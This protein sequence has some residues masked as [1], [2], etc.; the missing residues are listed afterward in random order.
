[1]TCSLK[2]SIFLIRSTFLRQ[3]TWRVGYDIKSVGF[4][5]LHKLPSCNK[6]IYMFELALDCINVSSPVIHFSSNIPNP[7]PFEQ[8]PDT[9]STLKHSAH[10]WWIIYFNSQIWYHTLFFFFVKRSQFH[11]QFVIFNIHVKKIV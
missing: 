9:W 1:M 8:F 10:V 7:H 2:S 3:N 6:H 4:Y 5:Q 11:K